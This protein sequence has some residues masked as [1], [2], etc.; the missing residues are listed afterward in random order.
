MGKGFNSLNNTT[1]ADEVPVLINFTAA[2]G[3]KPELRGSIKSIPAPILMKPV[4]EES[5][6][7]KPVKGESEE[8]LTLKGHTAPMPWMAY[9]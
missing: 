9:K 6:L 4:M 5:G 2:P 3:K 8:M 1:L 7:S